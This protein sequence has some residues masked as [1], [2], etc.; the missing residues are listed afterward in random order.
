MVQDDDPALVE[1]RQNDKKR[2]DEDIKWGL[3]AQRM[4]PYITAKQ[5]GQLPIAPLSEEY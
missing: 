5:Q 2:K 4:A 3:H 1:R